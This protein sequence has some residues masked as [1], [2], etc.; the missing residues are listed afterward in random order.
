MNI[1]VTEKRVSRFKKIF[2][3]N[4]NKFELEMDLMFINLKK[5]GKLN[6]RS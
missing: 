4:N 5:G 6:Y 3:E 2:Y 1:K